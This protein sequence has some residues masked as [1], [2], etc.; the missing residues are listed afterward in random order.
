MATIKPTVTAVG[1]G[2]GSTLQV[3][4]TPVTEADTCAAVSYPE[5]ADRSVQVAGT[6]GSSSTAVQGSIDGTNYASLNDPGGT[7]IALTA[8]GIKGILENTVYVKPVT[9]GG[10]SQS[11]TISML[12]HLTNPLRT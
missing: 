3:I 9:T 10:S 6:F 2:D 12:V 11:L 5:C 1:R 4:W 7:V 8:A